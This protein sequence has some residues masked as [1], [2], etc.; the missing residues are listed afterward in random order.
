ME[1]TLCFDFGN[2]RKKCA[3]FNGREVLEVVVLAD[4]AAETIQ[5][6]INRFQPKK[7]ILSSVIAHNP[8]METLLAKTTRFGGGG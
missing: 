8:E 5:D 4:D 3:V 6:L 1:V 7:S 2:S